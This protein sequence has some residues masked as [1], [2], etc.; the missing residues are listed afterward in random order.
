MNIT[1]LLPIAPPPN[2]N[3]K[4]GCVLHL[5]ANFVGENLVPVDLGARDGQLAPQGL[6]GGVRHGL[7]ALADGGL[8]GGRRSVSAALALRGTNPQKREFTYLVVLLLFGNDLDQLL[9]YVSISL[10]GE[11]K[12]KKPYFEPTFRYAHLLALNHVVTCAA[13]DYHLRLLTMP[14]LGYIC[15][16]T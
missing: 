6:E 11:F 8:D 4:L 7:V 9:R 14:L 5:L 2:H 1:F 15:R 10:L 3:L 16:M 13:K 12:K